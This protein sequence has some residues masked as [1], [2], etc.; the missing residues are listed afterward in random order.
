MIQ[1]AVILAAGQGKRFKHLPGVKHK[2]LIPF[3]GVSL[4]ELSITKLLKAGVKKIVIVL[5]FEGSEIRNELNSKFDQ[6]VH[7]VENEHFDSAGNLFSLIK[8][9]S[10]I[11]ENC[12]VLDADILYE[13][14]A[15]ERA[16][17]CENQNGIVTTTTSNSGDEVFVISEDQ[18]VK[19]ISKTL[20]DTNAIDLTEYVG[21]AFL[22]IYLVN[23]FKKVNIEDY[24]SF[25]YESFINKHL[26][27]DFNFQELFIPNLVW[28]EV[29]SENDYSKILNW[30]KQMQERVIV[31]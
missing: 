3:H 29:D 6:N 27:R 13:T 17:M 19:M 10:N 4:I 16:I 8:G 14:Q 28:S 24:V 11:D 20:E 18:E 7:F 22:N 31:S 25:D 15:V 26:L 1:T 9:V 30:S 12:L 2:C 5:G 23:Y 21:I